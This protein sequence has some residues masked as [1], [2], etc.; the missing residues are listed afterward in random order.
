MAEIILITGGSRS[1]KS[2]YAQRL[3]EAIPG[4]RAYIATCPVID[5]ET[6]ERVGKHREAR[7][8]SDW[9]TIE[10]TVDLAGAIRRSA[11]YRVILVDCLTLWVN[12]LLYEAEKRG[13]LITEEITAVRCREV[14]DACGTFPGTIIF[15]TNELGMGIIPDNETARRFRDCAGRCNQII[16]E[17]AG[18]VTLL[19]SGI[20][21]PL[22]R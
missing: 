11:A 18:A 1:G 6:A 21:F 2:G 22:K 10:E 14:I 8:S 19:V 3:A 7:R 4:P 16:A 15:V 13:D 20:P 9:E 5:P 12:S 17:A